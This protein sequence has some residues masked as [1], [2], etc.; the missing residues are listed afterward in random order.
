[1]MRRVHQ[2]MSE[3]SQYIKYFNMYIYI[4]MCV[5]VCVC[6]CVLFCIFVVLDNKLYKMHGT[7]IKIRLYNLLVYC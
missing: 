1:M 4:Y 7:Y 6:V 5:C 3:Y 2:N